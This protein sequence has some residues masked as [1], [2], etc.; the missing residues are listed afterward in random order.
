MNIYLLNAAFVRFGVIDEFETFIWA[1]RYADSGDFELTISPT[2]R[3]REL[4]LP[5]KYI[6]HSETSR[7]GVIDEVLIQ[8]NEVGAKIM[9]VTGRLMEAILDTRVITSYNFNGTR[10]MS[11]TGSIGDVVASMVSKICVHGLGVVGPDDII[12]ELY[13]ANTSGTTDVYKVGIKTQSLYT[14]VKEVCDSERLGFRIQL[15]P[16]SPRLRF[17]IYKGVVRPNVVFSSALDNLSEESYLKSHKSYRNMAYVIAKDEARV[18]IV[19][20][21]GVSIYAT[22]FKR[23]AMVVDASDIDPADSNTWD[24]F[25]DLLKRRGLEALAA[26]Q[27]LT[28]FDGSLTAFNPYIYRTH[29]SLGDIVT[30]IDEYNNKSQVVVSEYI[31]THDQQGLRAYPTFTAV[32]AA[33]T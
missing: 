16:T 24:E 12:P 8:E 3:M 5:G 28:L 15:L 17:N 18:E 10:S 33:D 7:L 21:P 30:Q 20:A 26:S 23:R 1:E 4:L 29:Y 25:R 2:L 11:I 14:S 31:W 32:E 6:S 13:V 9:T 27:R 19:P 22:G